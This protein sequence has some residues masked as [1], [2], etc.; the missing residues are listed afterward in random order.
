MFQEA[1][2]SRDSLM[3]ALRPR[4]A[5][6]GVCVCVCVCV[7]GGGVGGDASPGCARGVAAAQVHWVRLT[8]PRT[9]QPRRRART[10]GAWRSARPTPPPAPSR[11]RSSTPSSGPP[12]SSSRTGRWRSR[13]RRRDLTQSACRGGGG[14]GG[15]QVVARAVCVTRTCAPSSKGTPVVGVG[16]MAWSFDCQYLVGVATPL[17]RG[18][19]GACGTAI[20]TRVWCLC[21]CMRMCVCGYVC[22]CAAYCA[23]R[24]G[25]PERQPVHRYMDFC[26]RD[27]ESRSRHKCVR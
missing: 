26:S 18:G 21:V 25:C 17:A 19:G 23:L 24:A 3:E 27:R 9:P 14:G 20:M 1:L 13:R 12:T 8:S 7:G 11:S 6:E 22:V 4:A 16:A 2:E 5:G 15:A 10:W